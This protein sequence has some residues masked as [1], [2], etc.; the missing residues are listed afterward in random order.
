MN[1]VYG[2]LILALL[3]SMMAAMLADFWD[4]CRDAQHEA[5]VDELW[6]DE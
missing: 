1:L 3:F 2:L 6:G 5:L 4:A